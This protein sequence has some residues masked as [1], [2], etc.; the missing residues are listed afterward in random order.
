[1]TI[2]LAIARTT[3]DEVTG[4][5]VVL[6][7]GFASSGAQDW[8]ADRWARPLAA[9]GRETLVVDLPGHGES[10][11]VGSAAEATTG[12]VLE[13]LDEALRAAGADSVDVVGYSLGARLAWDLVAVSRVPVRRLVLGGLSPVEPFAAVDVAAARAAARGGDRPADQL[14]GMVLG[15]ASAPGR[16]TE[17]LLSLVEG[18]ASEPFDPAA[19]PPGVPALLVGGVDDP[20]SQGIDELAGHLPQGAVLRVPGDH[21]GALAGDEFRA[22]AVEFLR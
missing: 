6:I 13:K 9:A 5:A 8:P 22:A 12:R 2:D 20:M 1:M 3:P 15:M 17:S 18:L 4:P 16:D 19:A 21:L 7:H 10:P 14:T 11:R